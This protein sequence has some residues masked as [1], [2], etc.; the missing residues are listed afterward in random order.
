MD[1][2]QIKYEKLGILYVDN[3]YY[4]PRAWE[5]PGSLPLSHYGNFF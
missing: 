2:I 4:L 5:E 1:H 3:S